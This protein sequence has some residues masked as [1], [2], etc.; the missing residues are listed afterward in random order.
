VRW[1]VK[2]NPPYGLARQFGGR[3]QGNKHSVKRGGPIV[4]CF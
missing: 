3:L 4:C 2:E 1:R